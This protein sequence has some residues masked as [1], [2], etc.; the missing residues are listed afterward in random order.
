MYRVWPWGV[1]DV[2]VKAARLPTKSLR[3]RP[4]W[5]R[6]KF[7]PETVQ[8]AGSFLRPVILVAGGEDAYANAAEGYRLHVFVNNVKVYDEPFDGQPQ[9]QKAVFIGSEESD[10]PV[11]DRLRSAEGWKATIAKHEDRMFPPRGTVIDPT[12]NIEVKEGNSV[13]AVLLKKDGS[14]YIT[15]PSIIVA[16]V[17]ESGEMVQGL[18]VAPPP[19][20][21]PK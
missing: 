21:P 16:P 7:E 15:T 14:P 4:W 6:G 12:L 11:P 1:A 18:L 2:R 17:L 19:K 5:A 3:V 20:V 8:V 10:L 9:T 13:R